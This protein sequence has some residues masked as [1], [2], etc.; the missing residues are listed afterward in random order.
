MKYQICETCKIT[1]QGVILG[2]TVRK[3]QACLC[4]AKLV[5]TK[6]PHYSTE[7]K[8]FEEEEEEEED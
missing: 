5:N 1:L 4:K 3:C 2:Q 7:A 8:V 6:I